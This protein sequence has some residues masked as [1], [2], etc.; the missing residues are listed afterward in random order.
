MAERPRR[1]EGVRRNRPDRARLAR[2]LRGIRRRADAERAPHHL[3]ADRRLGRRISERFRGGALHRRLDDHGCDRGRHGSG[4]R[5]GRERMGPRA[6]TGGTKAPRDSRRDLRS[7]RRLGVARPPDRRDVVARPRGRLGRHRGLSRRGSATDPRAVRGRRH[8]R[9]HV[10]VRPGGRPVPGSGRRPLG[11]RRGGASGVDRARGRSRLR[12]GGRTTARDPTL[13]LPRGRAPEL[14]RVGFRPSPRAV[15]DAGVVHEPDSPSP[16]GLRALVEA[17]VRSRARLPG[18]GR[19]RAGAACRGAARRDDGPADRLPANPDRRAREAVHDL[20]VPNDARRRGARRWRGLG[21]CR[22]STRDAD[23]LAP[24]ADA[25]GRAS[26][27]AERASGRHVDRRAA[28]RTARVHPLAGG[29]RSLL[30]P[31]SARQAGHHRLGAGPLRLRR[32]LREH[33]RQAVLRPLV[34]PPPEP[35]HR[36]GGVR[37]DVL[38]RPR[39]RTARAPGRADRRRCGQH[40][41]GAGL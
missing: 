1:R 4:P 21:Q 13:P 15:C 28:P 9:E 23:R 22:R 41:R 35:G 10:P 19:P 32:R 34:S 8:G 5:D 33:G 24:A 29:G 30:G 14:L 18:P 3:A 26:T 37:Q 20:Q 38:H 2:G 16:A 7:G 11:D 25:P 40:E 31:A 17:D 27:V 12:R 39:P 36:P 6:G